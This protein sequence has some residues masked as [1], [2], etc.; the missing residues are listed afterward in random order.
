MQEVT[1]SNPVFSTS[2]PL[3][4]YKGLA[5]FLFSGLFPTLNALSLSLDYKSPIE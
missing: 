2:N 1:G 4:P 3:F 5:D